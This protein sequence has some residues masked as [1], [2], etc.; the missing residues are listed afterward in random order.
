MLFVVGGLDHQAIEDRGRQKLRTWMERREE[1]PVEVLR[2]FSGQGVLLKLLNGVKRLHARD[3]RENITTIAFTPVVI[4]G[5]R[6]PRSRTT[7]KVNPGILEFHMRSLRRVRSPRKLKGTTR[8]MT[9]NIQLYSE[10][11]KN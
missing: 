7:R 10:K 8:P 1:E 2:Y 4:E 6:S 11:T 3:G 9:R 5:L